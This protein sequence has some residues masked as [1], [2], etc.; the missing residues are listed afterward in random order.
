MLPQKG[1]LEAEH[2]QEQI[3]EDTPLTPGSVGLQTAGSLQVLQHREHA[4]H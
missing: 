2:Q 1:Y 4:I 3:A